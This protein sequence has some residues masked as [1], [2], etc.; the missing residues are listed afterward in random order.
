[1]SEPAVEATAVESEVAE[2][3]QGDPVVEPSASEVDLLR[4]ALAKANKEAEKNR[5]RL[6]EVDDAK[7]SEMDK[8]TQRATDAE[9]RANKL[10]QTALRQKVALTKGLPANLVDRLQ[11]DDEDSLIADADSLLALLKTPTSPR[12]DP[13]QGAKPAPHALNG[14]PL[15]GAL[16]SKLGIN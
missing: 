8:A 2:A 15:L 5:L 4:S 7:L 6:K 14:D 3:T 10:E 11:G 16:K 12:A 9:A 1:M 13:S